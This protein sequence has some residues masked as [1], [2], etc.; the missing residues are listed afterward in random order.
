MMTGTTEPGTRVDWRQLDPFLWVAVG[1]A[2]HLGT[3]EQG[4]RYVVVDT[5]GRVRGRCRTLRHA[6]L[7]LEELAPLVGRVPSAAAA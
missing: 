6:Q 4:R 1:P 2:G 7:L 5:W 3:V